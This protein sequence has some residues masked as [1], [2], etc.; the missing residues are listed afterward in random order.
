MKSVPRLSTVRRSVLIIFILLFA[1]SPLNLPRISAQSALAL[2]EAEAVQ[3][4][5]PAFRLERVKVDGGAELLTIHGRLEGLSLKGQ[6]AR[7]I[8]TEIEMQ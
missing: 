3:R 2:P 6:G 5:A 1:F 7:V 4:N 8:V